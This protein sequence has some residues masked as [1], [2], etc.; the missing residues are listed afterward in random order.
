MNKKIVFGLTLLVSMALLVS[1]CS[2]AFT[3]TEIKKG[4]VW[5]VKKMMSPSNI[6]KDLPITE[7][8]GNEEVTINKAFLCLH[9]NKKVYYKFIGK[10]KWLFNGKTEVIIGGEP[11][12]INKDDKKIT[13]G[14][15]VLSYTLNGGLL[16]LRDDVETTE[17]CKSSSE[18][19]FSN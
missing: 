15:H 17:V 6:L 3:P 2:N 19:E 14:R 7:K 1:G 10:G 5:E 16:T 18:P 4:S 12:T 13:M 8:V 9:S 11:Y